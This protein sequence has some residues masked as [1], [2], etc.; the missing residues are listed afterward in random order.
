MRI[1]VA[2]LAMISVVS[3]LCTMNV[4]AVS[5]NIVISQIQLG[6]TLSASN[7]LIEVYNN[8]LS[9]ID[10]TNWCA[11]YASSASIENG[12]KVAC[13]SPDS[14]AIHLYLPTH[15]F[16]FAV[17]TAFATNYPA[18]GSDL[19][20]AAT[21]SG[22]AGHI[23]IVDNGG[24]IIDKVGWGS[25]I[26]PETKSIITAPNGKVLQRKQLSSGTLIDTDDNS[27]DFELAVPRPLYSYGYIYEV[28]DLCTNIRGIQ[29]VLPIGY[30][31]DIA[32]NCEPPLIDLCTNIEGLQTTLLPGYEYDAN[33]LCQPDICSNLSGFQANVP[34]GYFINDGSVCLLDV[35]PVKV[36]ELLANA[37]GLDSGKEFIELYNPNDVGIDLSLYLLKIG[38]TSPQLYTF[39]VGSY[40]NPNDYISFTND[41]IAFTLLNT[42]SQVSVMSSDGQ[43]IDESPQYINPADGFAW[44]FINGMWQYTNQPT[45][46]SMNKP[47]FIEPHDEEIVVEIKPCAAG[48]YRSLETN[49][50]RVLVTAGSTLVACKDG[51]YRSETTSRCRSIA[52]DANVLSACN[53]NQ[54]R[55][56]ET[57]RCK[58]IASVST[59]VVACKDGQERNTETNRCRNIIASA[60]IPRAAFAVEPISDTSSNVIGWWAV[61]GVL[62]IGLAYAVW[63][64]RQE[65]AHIVNKVGTFF[66]SH[67]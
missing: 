35:L 58:L 54:E 29:S 59:E 48:Q 46:A 57:N 25:A 9:D 24:I 53:A 39:P 62:A 11:Y 15:S 47:S 60:N 34:N 3:G 14:T 33:G 2:V 17:S 65:V 51:Q 16:A 5:S 61:G 10:I 44:A 26:S 4:S 21:L 49:R 55:N 36:N 8:S 56:T 30:S 41:T 22:T 52:T 37:V 23:R 13:F 6:T 19:R 27:L 64:W 66:H 50:C 18:V 28:Q 42:T 67:K 7:E 12:S 1:V 20:F 63:E 43:V 40:I 31:V 38:V 45:P 32:G